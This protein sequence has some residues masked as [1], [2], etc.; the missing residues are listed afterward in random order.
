MIIFLIVMALTAIAV[1]LAKKIY[2]KRLQ[3]DY[4]SSLLKG[5]RKKSDQLGKMYYLSLNEATRKARGIID[6]DAR[7]SEDFRSFNQTPFTLL[8]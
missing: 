2:F 7:I 6:I 1:Y 4:E 3:T 5:D 8:F